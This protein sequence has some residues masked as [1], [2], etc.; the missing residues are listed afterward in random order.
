MQRARKDSEDPKNS[1]RRRSLGSLA[2][3][4]INGVRES[5]DEFLRRVLSHLAF[6]FSSLPDASR[7][8]AICFSTKN[9]STLDSRLKVLFY[10][11]AYAFSRC[12]FTQQAHFLRVAHFSW[13]LVNACRAEIEVS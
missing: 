7:K 12:I 8:C 10:V 3:F 5:R 1:K 6:T 4:Q 13:P 9:S 11:F 2:N